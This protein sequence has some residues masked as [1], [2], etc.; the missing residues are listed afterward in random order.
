VFAHLDG[1]QQDAAQQLFLR[2]VTVADHDRWTRRRVFA[3][4]I[5]SMEVDV[6]AL[7]VVIERFG[8]HRFL[9]FDRDPATGAPTLEVAHEALLREWERVRGWIEAARGD[10]RRHAALVGAIEEWTEAG[11]DPDY[12]LGGARL[13]EYERWSASTA[14]R[15]TAAERQYLSASAAHSHEHEAL[16][17][18]RLAQ[19]S[20]LRRRARYS[21]VALV[22]AL[23]VLAAVTVPALLR[24]SHHPRSVV[25]AGTGGPIQDLAVAGLE[26]A[27]L[28]GDIDVRTIGPPFGDVEAALADAVADGA[29]MVIALSD[30]TVP[31]M[32]LAAEHPDVAWVLIEGPPSTGPVESVSFAEEQGSFLAGAAAALTT[33]TGTIGF[34]GGQQYSQIEAFRAGYEAGA[35]AVDPDVEVLAR[36]V[37]ADGSG[38][39][40]DDLAAEAAAGMY[41][42]GADVVYHAAGVAGLGVFDAARDASRAA[43]EQRWA[44]GVDTDQ[45]LEVDQRLQPFVLTS[46]VKRYDFV[47]AGLIDDLLAGRFAPGV[48]RVTLADQAMSL[49]DSGGFLAP[50]D[51]AAL[52]ALQER[53]VRGD[54]VVPTIPGGHLDPPPEA[55]TVAATTIEFDGR[56]CRYDGPASLLAGTTVEVDVRNETGADAVVGLEDVVGP[57]ANGPVVAGG[58]AIVYGTA[59]QD[60]HVECYT[61]LSGLTP[62]IPSETVSVPTA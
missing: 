52:D 9:A 54:I 1:A 29:D 42:A 40:R 14:M 55:G 53:I 38:F 44:I 62:G 60:F 5:L 30:L 43:G 16:V 57:F 37:A 39:V 59:L 36:Y 56:T 10:L 33:T 24:S 2:L 47:V 12:L 11:E 15:L 32:A 28:A 61:D 7:Q 17:T 25:L 13:G 19:E 27:R 21:V 6:V 20:H 22:V 49:S 18:S 41:D 3:S 51:R 58:R 8:A 46:M 35:H 50:A 26:P 45:Y 34:V 31:A 48:D 4:E 23:A